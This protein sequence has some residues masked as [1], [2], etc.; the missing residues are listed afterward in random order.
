[1]D[2]YTASFRF[3]LACP[4]PAGW[5]NAILLHLSSGVAVGGENQWS[6]FSGQLAVFGRVRPSPHSKAQA[7]SLR[8]PSRNPFWVYALTTRCDNGK[9]GAG[10]SSRKIVRDAKNAKDPP[11]QI[12]KRKRTDPPSAGRRGHVRFAQCR[13]LSYNKFKRGKRTDLEVC[14]TKA[15][16]TIPFSPV[17]LRPAP[18]DSGLRSLRKTTQGKQNDRQR[19]KLRKSKA[20]ASSRTP[21]LDR[22]L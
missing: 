8:Y 2:R 17:R 22:R 6:V 3:R 7:V 19:S 5:G 20:G 12:Q 14:P 1:M 21:N 10:G 15:A 16:S 4:P 9:R 13:R 18:C 11:L